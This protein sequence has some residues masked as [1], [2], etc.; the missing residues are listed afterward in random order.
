MS[1]PK[2][3]H[4][5]ERDGG[6]E[7]CPKLVVARGGAAEVLE[8]TEH[9]FNPP[10]VSVSTLVVTDRALPIDATRDDRRGSCLLQRGAEPARVVTAIGDQRLKRIAASMR[11]SAARMSEVLPGVSFSATGRPRRS[12]IAWILVVRP[13][14]E[15]PMAFAFAPLLR[16][17]RSGGPS[18]RSSRD[19]RSLQRGLARQGS[20][21]FA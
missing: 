16:H 9:G 6:E 13:P 5:C 14:R 4:G 12:Q 10:T 20:P 19:S 11:S 2:R 18:R 8:A 17:A 21:G 7:V 15:T 1:C 3:D